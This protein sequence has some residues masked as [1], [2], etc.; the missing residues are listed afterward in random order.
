MSSADHS[1]SHCKSDSGAETEEQKRQRNAALNMLS[2]VWDEA[3]RHLYNVYRKSIR[4]DL[5]GAVKEL[6]VT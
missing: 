1:L 4:M 6:K 5:V 2:S 3:K